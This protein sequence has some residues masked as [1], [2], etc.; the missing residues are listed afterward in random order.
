MASVNKVIVIGYLGRDP[1]VHY[2]NDGNQ[3]TQ[4]S[5]A[6]T[7]RWK[8][9]GQDKEITTWF[10]VQCFKR[11]AEIA[12]EYLKKGSLCYVEGRLRNEEWT[13]KQGQKRTTAKVHCDV[14][15][16]LD[17]K[18]SGAASGRPSTERPSSGANTAERP[19]ER[20]AIDDEK[21]PF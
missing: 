16:L 4:F 7:E 10:N 8:Q 11:V 1:E 19:A 14:L 18:A 2:F 21:M 3:S 15:R 6:A 9:D 20:R 13:D 12:S 5:V 17:S